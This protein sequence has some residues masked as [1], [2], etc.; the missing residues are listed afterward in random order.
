MM[1]KE[2]FPLLSVIIPTVGRP[3]FLPRAV[4]SAFLG[5]P[6]EDLEVIVVPNGPDQSWRK[7]LAAFAGDSRLRCKAIATAHVSA[8]RNHGM[9]MARGKYVRFLD[10]DDYLLPSAILQVEEL[11]RTGADLC[12]GLVMNVDR[13]GLSLGTLSFPATSDFVCASV[14][15]SGFSLPLG[16][17]FRR[18]LLG[19][20]RW[21]E[22]VKSQED[23]I[24]LA[25]LAAGREWEWRHLNDHVG[26]WYQHAN[27]RVSTV[28]TSTEHPVKVVDAFFNLINTLRD[29]KRLTPARARAVASALLGFCHRYFPSAPLYWHKVAVAAREIDPAAIP[30]HAVFANA[31]L[32][33]PDFLALEWAGLPLRLLSR[34]IRDTK[35]RLCGWDYRRR[36]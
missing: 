36:L 12:S 4:T 30:D 17:V 23:L 18:G 34:F 3:E 24:W 14:A 21:D 11:E 28:R 6:S 16:N 1:A 35:G 22:T 19:K 33:R 27:V 10:D 7:S 2:A 26:V 20:F 25:T 5:A 15:L 13:E 9:A 8:A 31:M 29:E 32:Q